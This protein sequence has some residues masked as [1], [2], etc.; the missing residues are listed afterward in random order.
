VTQRPVR[1]RGRWSILGGLALLAVG[2]VL[3]APPAPRAL[4]PAAFTIAAPAIA[5]GVVH[6]HTT[7]SDGSGT[8][9][10][11]AA[12]A[13]RAGLQFV[14]ATD[15]GDGTRPPLPPAY[16][17]GVLCLDGV[18][19]STTGGHYLAFGLGETPYRLA[20][21]PSE[22]VEDV[23]RLG[24]F[25]AAAHPD[26]SKPELAWRDWSAAIDGLEWFNLDSEWRDE[27]TASLA[28][29]V[30]FYPFR[31]VGALGALASDGGQLLPR[32]AGLAR[33][34][35][36][37]GLAGVDAH[38][39]LGT[40]GG[41]DRAWVNLRAPGY[42]PVFEAAQVSV[43]LD[44][45]LT[46][47]AGRDAATVLGALRE[48]RSFSTIAA[49]APAGRL[50]LVAERGGQRARMGQFLGGRGPVVLTVEADAP[51]GA[52]AR[53]SCDGRT[54]TQTFTNT[55]FARSMDED[56]A[57]AACQ[58][59]VGWP[60]G[61]PDAFVT[62]AVTNPIYLRPGDPPPSIA[63]APVA[64]RSE[65]LA[66]GPSA[67][68]VEHARGSDAAL[69]GIAPVTLTYALAPGERASQYA[70]LVAT[71]VGGLSWARWLRVTLSADR[72]MRV[73]LQLRDP[74]GGADGRRWQRSLV[75]GPETTTHVV[76]LDGFTPIDAGGGPL[77]V[78][79]IRAILIVVDTVHTPP[80][81]RGTVTLH[82]LRAEAGT[83]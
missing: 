60:G 83:P 67:W 27:S 19:I 40:E 76:P 51:G 9:D 59:I 32:W 10:E 33:T 35:R 16:R 30:L 11:V 68:A 80:G 14:I 2:L 75:I 34:R 38:A 3:A 53:L 15:H 21:E 62:W 48:G 74:A 54:V 46:G 24:G 7:R 28:R 66:V 81:R 29:A 37:V 61:A 5:R 77:P 13:S 39:R 42:E 25:G 1:R 79:S 18:E 82:E 20:G 43:E 4:Q 78:T 65:G 55:T 56:E 41:F 17:S 73:S 31:P 70:A 50:A 57:G 12:A 44:A 23:R 63:A 71:D 47:D 22:V 49:R 64:A 72:P 26:S 45:P 36:V 8:I 69:A 52:V 58:A 6:V